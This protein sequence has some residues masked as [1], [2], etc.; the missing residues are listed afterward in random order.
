VVIS[1]RAREAFHAT[2]PR[3]LIKWQHEFKERAHQFDLE[4]GHGA[5]LPSTSPHMVEN[6]SDPSVTASFT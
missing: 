5:Y 2:Q 6:G 1:E 4:P 3:D